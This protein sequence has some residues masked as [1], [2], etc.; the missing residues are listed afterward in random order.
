MN[1]TLKTILAAA[2]T[3]WLPAL[4]QASAPRQQQARTAPTGLAL[5]L[6]Y[7]E[8][9]PPAYQ[10]VLPASGGGWGAWYG[11]FRMVPNWQQPA[12]TLPVQAVQFTPRVEGEGVRVVVSVHTGVKHHEKEE[13]VASYFV[14][15]DESVVVKE[16]RRFGVEPFAFKLVRV[17]PLP[18]NPPSVVSRAESITAVRVEAN[19]ST[20]PSYK[21]TV[22]NNSAKDVMALTVQVHAGGRLRISSMP[23]DRKGG[24]LIKAGA[25]HALD[26]KIANETLKRQEGYAP[27]APPEQQI[28]INSAVFKD[29]SYEGDA[30]DAAT[31]RAYVVGDRVQ[32]A[33]VVDA[34]RRVSGA[35]PA[36]VALSLGALR[37]HIYDLGVEPDADVTDALLK[38]F[39]SLS[40]AQ[41]AEVRGAIGV[42]MNAHKTDMLELIKQLERS[43]PPDARS[44]GEWLSATREKYE[45]LLSGPQ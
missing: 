11:L 34:L 42:S 1:K 8:G 38:D 31:Y 37:A 18:T 5:E 12:E 32:V 45:R 16:L 23:Q 4:S 44:F 19:N 22:Q 24:T 39:P 20:L 10:V 15:L 35:N 36:D 2:L 3:L 40:E 26:V 43:G 17:S 7:Y 30:K 41:Q 6:T 25:I 27:S 9:R 21:V 33:R 13:P 29:G 28:V 14:R